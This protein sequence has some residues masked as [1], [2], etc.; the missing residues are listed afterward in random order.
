MTFA[1]GLFIGGHI[2]R[3][4]EQ[5]GLD[6][7]ALGDQAGQ[8][9][10]G[11]PLPEQAR[12]AKIFRHPAFFRGVLFLGVAQGE[13]PVAAEFPSVL[14]RGQGIERGAAGH[15]EQ[16]PYTLELELTI[17][18]SRHRVAIIGV[19]P[20]HSR[21]LD[22]RPGSIR[23]FDP[24]TLLQQRLAYRPGDLVGA[25]YQYA[26]GLLF[27]Q[28]QQPGRGP[29]GEALHHHGDDNHQEC[30]GHE[31]HGLGIARILQAQREQGGNGGGDDPPGGYPCHQ[32]AFAP[33]VVTTKSRCPDHYWPRQ[34]HHQQ[35]PQPAPAGGDNVRRVDTRS[36]HDEQHGDDQYGQALLE[37]KY[38]CHIDTAGI[39]QPDPHN[40]DRQ[41]A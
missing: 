34:Q 28:A 14:D 39:A 21:R 40:G 5:G 9:L 10:L 16:A 13:N 35:H 31:Q 22:F 24:K 37:A 15:G 26:T 17:G 38:L 23:E 11:N 36:Q 30:V 8:F 29:G 32:G 20:V 19:Q 27:Y 18:V 33:A 2:E 6:L 3:I 25:D 41:Q 4:G 12:G 7:R 1:P